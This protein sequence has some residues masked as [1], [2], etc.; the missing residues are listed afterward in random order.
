MAKRLGFIGGTGPEG[1]GLAARFA[2]AG[3]DVFIG[4]RAAQKGEAAAAEVGSLTKAGVRG[5]T[6][7]D[8]VR[9]ADV[10][11]VT[12]PYAGLRETLTALAADLGERIVVSAV[13]PLQFSKGKISA[14]QVAEGSAAQEAQAVVPT[15]KVVGAFQ[16]LAAG[17][18]LDLE[19]EI[20]GD[21]LVT[22]DDADAVREVMALAELISGI[23]AVNA[24]PL[25]NSRYVEDVTALLLNINRLYKTETH[26]RILGL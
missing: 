18:L 3:I 25:A 19:H 7:V 24:G 22:G 13:V 21:V 15:A 23:R 4:S 5:G 10:V 12:I 2:A 8:A 1:K 26:V 17:H 11:I 9:A 20:E 6:N 16:N 14:L